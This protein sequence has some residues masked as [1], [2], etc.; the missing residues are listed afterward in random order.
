MAGGRPVINIEYI[1]LINYILLSPMRCLC[2]YFH[3]G[4]CYIRFGMSTCENKYGQ[5]GCQH[6]FNW[7]EAKTS[8]APTLPVDRLIVG[9]AAIGGCGGDVG[10]D[11][12]P[13]Q[14]NLFINR[15]SQQ[16]LSLKE[17]MNWKKNSPPFIC[18]RRQLIKVKNFYSFRVFF[19]AIAIVDK[20][21][22]F[23]PLPYQCAETKLN[24]YFVL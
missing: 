7:C 11:M 13:A 8:A 17:T 18:D 9:R 21:W 6:P 23:D 12:L 10:G 3:V 19:L 5:N 24:P 1:I 2:K 4:N 15:R 20:P 16:F 22:I 14:H